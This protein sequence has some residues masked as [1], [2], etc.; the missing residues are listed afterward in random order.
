MYIRMSR[1]AVSSS[2]A[3]VMIM[4]MG[5][6]FI[7]SMDKC[8]GEFFV[9][10]GIALLILPSSSSSMFMI[11]VVAIFNDQHGG[12]TFSYMHLFLLLC[13][14]CECNYMYQG[15]G[16]N[17]TLLSMSPLW[18]VMTNLVITLTWMN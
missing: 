18:M 14:T 13:M 4:D 7:T 8:E 11:M 3:M 6:L 12:V 16:N 10:H 1:Y 9:M 5:I 2:C 17:S 15:I